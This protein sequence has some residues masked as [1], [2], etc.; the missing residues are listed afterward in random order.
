M[1]QIFKLVRFQ[2]NWAQINWITEMIQKRYSFAYLGSWEVCESRGQRSI[3]PL[4]SVAVEL[5]PPFWPKS[6]H[7]RYVELYIFLTYMTIWS[8]WAKF[9][10]NWT[11][12]KIWPVYKR[13]MTFCCFGLYLE[14]ETSYGFHVIDYFAPYD[15]NKNLICI[16]TKLNHFHHS[17]YLED[18]W[19]LTPCNDPRVADFE[20]C[21]P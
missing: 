14:N 15:P 10:W 1:G 18:G 5:W 3:G 13:S 2:W 12:L 19:T 17:T 6:G 8:I 21:P 9:H 4:W 7:L 16:T 11:N 20:W